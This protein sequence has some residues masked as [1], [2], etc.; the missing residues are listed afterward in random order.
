M[1]PDS[2]PAAD[3]PNEA[4]I[5]EEAL[6]IERRRVIVHN[7]PPR[8][9]PDELEA[10]FGIFGPISDL[11]ILCTLTQPTVASVLFEHP[12]CAALAVQVPTANVNGAVVRLHSVG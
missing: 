10:C 12:E 9:R 2:P 7:T 3:D 4:E 11:K 1:D 5:R 8:T 6:S